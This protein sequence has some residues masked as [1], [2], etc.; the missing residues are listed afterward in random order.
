MVIIIT[1]NIT[2]G[3]DLLGTA[4]AASPSP[5]R[6]PGLSVLPI[7][8]HWRRLRPVRLIPPRLLPHLGPD[9]IILVMAAAIS[10]LQALHLHRMTVS[11]ALQP[12]HGNRKLSPPH[13]YFIPAALG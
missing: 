11:A 1:S 7:S 9:Y 4:T 2:R 5:S 8:R 6:P 12:M 3:A 13:I 10:M